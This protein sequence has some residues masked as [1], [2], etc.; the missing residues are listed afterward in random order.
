MGLLND[1][2][3]ISLRFVKSDGC[4]L[5]KRDK[6]ESHDYKNIIKQRKFSNTIIEILIV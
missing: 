3:E 1:A 4:I 6:L 5:I 2:I